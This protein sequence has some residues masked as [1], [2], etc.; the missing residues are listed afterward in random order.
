M[1]V[2]HH[3]SHALRI[4][5]LPGNQWL[6]ELDKLSPEARAECEPWLRGQAKRLRNRRPSASL[7]GPSVTTNSPTRRR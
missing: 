4:L 1:P 3:L 5:K 2:Y 7:S 6:A